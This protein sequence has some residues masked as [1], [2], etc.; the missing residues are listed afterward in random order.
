MQQQVA[1]ATQALSERQATAAREAAQVASATLV[2]YQPL[3][4]RLQNADQ[5]LAA[6]QHALPSLPAGSHTDEVSALIEQGRTA[7]REAAQTI[8]SPTAEDSVAEAE[9]LASHAFKLGPDFANT[10]R[11]IRQRL[12]ALNARGP[13]MNA[14]LEQGRTEFDIVDEYAP[15]S[16]SDIRGNGSEATA[17]I[18][19]AHQL[20]QSAQAKVAPDVD[21]NDWA[22]A[23]NDVETAEA[24]LHYADELLRVIST[25]LHDLREA[26]KNAKREV[27]NAQRDV[28]LGWGY[29][30][31][32]D[33]D[34]GKEPEQALTQAQA[35]L[36]EI[37]RSLAN[38]QPNWITALQQATQARQLADLALAGARSEVDTMSAKRTQADS[39]AQAAQAEFSK[40]TNFA[41]LHPVEVEAKHRREIDK[42]TALLGRATTRL[43]TATHAEETARLTALAEAAALFTQVIETAQPLYSSMYEAFQT[44]EALRQEASGAVDVA[45]QSLNNTVSWY[46]SYG[47]VM[48]AGSP[49]QM[50][51]QQAQQTLRP[52]NP[53]A[54]AKELKAIAAAAKEANRLAHE[55][56]QSIQQAAQAY[57]Q[58]ATYSSQRRGGGADFGD[59]LTGMFIGSMMNGGGHRD[60]NHGWGSGSGGG[61]IFGGGG[62]GGGDSGGSSGGWGGGG[63]S[64][65]GS[66]G[67]WGGGGDSGGSSGSW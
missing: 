33:A 22:G 36:A 49:G 20:W 47:Y 32:N 4:A 15:E 55:A 45:Q 56:A 40:L 54:K 1:R 21:V 67:G 62:G 14:R 59:L 63:D 46:S 12:D 37:S 50:L 41:K 13:E 52:Y 51:L 17:A 43:E 38:E 10:Q 29:I 18:G 48:P 65:G 53:Q 5:Q 8:D 16:W 25:R 11:D 23:L 24:R 19:Q 61:G 28:K 27:E 66:S 34:V 44:M 2:Q 57:Q 42:I 30:R 35:L 39:L 31:N 58:T 9:R 6:A 7:L 60:N 64:G 26:Q 3:L